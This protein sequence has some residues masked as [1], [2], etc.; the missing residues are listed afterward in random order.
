MNKVINNNEDFK[1]GFFEFLIEQCDD[2]FELIQKEIEDN[3]FDTFISL[4]NEEN[5]INI[6]DMYYK[7]MNEFNLDF[8]EIDSFEQFCI[9]YN[10]L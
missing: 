9:D 6:K 8:N 2:L 5:K 7:N 1:D 10:I 3:K 4:I